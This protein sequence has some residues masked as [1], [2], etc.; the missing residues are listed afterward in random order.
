LPSSL[1][2]GSGLNKKYGI[3]KGYIKNGYVTQGAELGK[4]DGIG[5]AMERRYQEICLDVLQAAKRQNY[6][7]YSKFDALNSSL[8][9]TMSMGNKWLRMIYTQ[10]VN[11][12]PFHLRPLLGVKKSCNPKGIALFA[13]A[14]LFL[15]SATGDELYRNEAEKLLQWL[16]EN[17]SRGS[18]YPSWGYNFIWQNTIFLQG[19]NE[20]NCVVSVFAGEA[21]V[22][23]YRLLKDEKYFLVAK[24]IANFIIKEL[25]VLFESRSEMAIGY[26]QGKSDCVV[27]NINALAGAFL[28]K[29]WKH[30][31]EQKLLEF[32]KKLLKFTVN[33]RTPYNAWYYTHPKES[34]PIKHDNYHTGG[35]LDALLEYFEETGDDQY[36]TVYWKGL[37][38][39]QKH[40]F[41]Q[42]GAPRWMNNKKY[43]FDIHGAAQGIISFSKAARHKRGFLSQAERI[44]DWTI[45]IL[46]RKQTRDF[47]YRQGRYMTWNYSLMRWCNA[48]MA[49]ALGEILSIG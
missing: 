27:L 8:L 34:S 40:L 21:F 16:I 30:S 39:Y 43:P 14:Y 33:R 12:C 4:E 5:L 42:D 20:P 6:A 47:A 22:H 13:R 1:A 32:A 37:D 7:G 24:E 11:R 36:A 49:R 19:M 44:A 29:V 9:K 45:G 41:E 25:P 3:S 15:Y 17:R 10:I 26:V 31:Q 38:Y 46:Y 18:S 23:A 2:R 28:V 35:I 48:W